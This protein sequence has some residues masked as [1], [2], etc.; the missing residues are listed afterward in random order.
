MDIEV[1][2]GGIGRIEN[3]LG[4]LSCWSMRLI[5]GYLGE[6]LVIYQGVFILNEW[7]HL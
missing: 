7:C 1:P 2:T 5:S 4:Q 6:V 3:V